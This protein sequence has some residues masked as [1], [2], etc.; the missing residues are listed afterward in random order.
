MTFTYDKTDDTFRGVEYPLDLASKLG[1]ALVEDK[2]AGVRIE[3]EIKLLVRGSG[4]EKLVL[5]GVL[6]DRLKR[7][8]QSIL[9]NVSDK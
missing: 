7:K 1:K 6:T 4:N 3:R 2:D 8:A 9:D 5:S